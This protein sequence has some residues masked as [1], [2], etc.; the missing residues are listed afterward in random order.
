MRGARVNGESSEPQNTARKDV[1]ILISDDPLAAWHVLSGEIAAATDQDD[2]DSIGWYLGLLLDSAE[3]ILQTRLLAA[4][5]SANFRK[6]LDSA[7]VDGLS[8]DFIDAC[9]DVLTSL[10]AT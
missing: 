9:I 2:F 8:E 3:E 4:L 1:D 10:T 7:G 5:R 6:A